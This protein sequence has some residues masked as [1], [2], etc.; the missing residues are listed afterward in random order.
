MAS[1][2]AAID[3]GGT[4][5][6]LGLVDEIGILEQS[7]FDSQGGARFVELLQTVEAEIRNLLHKAGRDVQDLH[8]VGI[9]IPGIV[10]TDN[11]RLISVNE[12]YLDAIEFDFASWAREKLGADVEIENDARCA[13]IGEWQFGT[14]K[15]YDDLVMVT[16]GTGVGG[17]ALING[18]VLRGKHF[19]A[20]CLC[21][22][23]VVDYKGVPCTCGNVGC[24]E[25]VASSWRLPTMV[26]AHPDYQNSKLAFKESI[27]FK[28]LFEA[29]ENNDLLA[30]SIKNECISAWAAGITTMIH[31]YDPELVVMGGGIMASANEIIPAIQAHVDKR[32][33]TPWGQVKVAK[34]QHG[35][36]S[37]LLGA[38]YLTFQKNNQT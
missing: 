4:R 14:G 21:G 11:K 1:L 16:L 26:K 10:D 8:G 36:W 23:F 18:K 9:S 2:A 35:G 24:V 31:A 29:A 30:I 22:H 34:A 19:Q 7:E 17:A 15:G 20:G 32:A 27:D 33:W 6:K 12:K 5:V 28:A 13:M 3:L 38:G 25:S 37:A